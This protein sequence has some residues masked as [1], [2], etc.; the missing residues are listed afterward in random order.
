M[1]KTFICYN[2][3]GHGWAKVPLAVVTA[4]GITEGHFSS[5]SYRNGENLFLEEDCDIGIF[6]RA[7][8]A[9]TGEKPKF[10]D[11][12]C[13][14]RSRIRNYLSCRSGEPYREYAKRW[15]ENR[16]SAA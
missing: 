16:G 4:I 1:Q 10:T 6:A 11:R 9:A 12:Y 5:Y 3:P 15:E 2:D 7:Y 14:G 8:E 13:D